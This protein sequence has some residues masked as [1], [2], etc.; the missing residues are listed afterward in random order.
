LPQAGVVTGRSQA[1]GELAGSGGCSS[2]TPGRRL[3]DYG[4]GWLDVLG[5]VTFCMLLVTVM[6]SER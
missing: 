1:V 2:S 4:D 3:L 5:D 6:A